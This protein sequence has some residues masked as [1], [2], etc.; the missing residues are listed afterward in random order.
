MTTTAQSQD[1]GPAAKPTPADL[2]DALKTM[3]G[4][5]PNARANFAK[6]VCVKGAYTPSAFAPLVTKSQS[7]TRPSEVL[8]RF[9]VSSGNPHVADTNK[10]ALKGFSFRVGPAG[11]QSDIVTENAPVHFARDLTQMLA[12][13]KARTAGPDGKVDP[14]KFKAFGAANPEALNQAHLVGAKPLPGSWAGTIYWGVHAFPATDA[15]GQTRHIKFKVVPHI[16]EVTLSEDEAKARPADF[17]KGDLEQRLAGGPV[18]FDVLAIL[19]QP[20]DQVLDTTQRWVNEDHRETIRLGTI[21]ITSLAPEDSC[22]AGIFNP[23]A[24]ADGIA[25]PPDEIFA[26]RAP[27]YAISLGRRRGG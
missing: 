6:G 9:A 18:R 1:V 10:G 13:L 5:P 12:S 14:E 15:K 7:F 23:A 25:A 19:G 8:G 26:A 4:N 16:A 21:S 20:D 11:H 3:A 2:V 17:L 22:D 27:A 24:L